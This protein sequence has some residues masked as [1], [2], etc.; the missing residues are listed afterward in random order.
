MKASVRRRAAW[1]SAVWKPCVVLAALILARP[2]GVRGPVL[3]PPCMRQRPLLI[4]GAWQG[5]PVRVFA[6]QRG[7]RFR[8]RHGPL[9]GCTAFS[10]ACLM[11][12]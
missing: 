12:R 8:L 6:P 2:S 4:A 3:A 1:L 10:S 11:K 7:A 5:Q 9:R